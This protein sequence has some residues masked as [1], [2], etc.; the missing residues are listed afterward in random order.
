MGSENGR[1]KMIVGR[2]VT[3]VTT[4]TGS[5]PGGVYEGLFIL[6]TA[7]AG[8]GKFFDRHHAEPPLRN[9]RLLQRIADPA[10]SM[11]YELRKML[12]KVARLC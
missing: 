2:L 7:P 8:F 10:F 1:V 9:S 11:A 5:D 6:G 12:A 4:A 3:S